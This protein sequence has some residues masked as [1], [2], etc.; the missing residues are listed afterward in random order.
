MAEKVKIPEGVLLLRENIVQRGNLFGL[1]AKIKA[2]WARGLKLPNEGD[3]ILFTGCGYEFLGFTKPLTSILRK[4]EKVGVERSVGFVRFIE[5]LGLNL[6]EIYARLAGKDEDNE[7]LRATVKVLR[8]LG[9]KLSYLGEEEPCCGAPLYFLGFQSDFIK[10]AKETS[11]FLKRKGVKRIIS[12]VPSCTYALKELYPRF[13]NDFDIEV[14]FILEVLAEQMPQVKLSEPVVAVYHDPCLLSRYLGLRE[15]PRRI[16]KQ[17]GN[18][19]LKETQW[20]QREWST[21]CGGGGGFEVVFPELSLLLA[22]RRVEELL[23]SK[24]QA[25]ITSCPGCFLQLEEGLKALKVEGVKVVD[26]VQILARAMEV[27]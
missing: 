5:K 23:E 15:E 8:A 7:V 4:T 24:P 10:R 18:L 14:K 13:L 6:P 16:L 22:Q 1:P 9:I 11:T 21:C 20:T 19:E 3:T 27:R 25:I 17:V 26:L 12:L 2:S